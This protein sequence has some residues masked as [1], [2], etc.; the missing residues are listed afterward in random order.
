MAAIVVAGIVRERN[1]G[2]GAAARVRRDN[3]AHCTPLPPAH[4]HLR[5]Q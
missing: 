2:N 5:V 1:V 4:L 3:P